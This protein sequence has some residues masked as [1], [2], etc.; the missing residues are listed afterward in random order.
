[1]ALRWVYRFTALTMSCILVACS[2]TGCDGSSGSDLRI[3][4]WSWSLPSSG[5]GTATATGTIHNHS[6]GGESGSI[7]LRLRL[8]TAPYGDGGTYYETVRADGLSQLSGGYYRDYTV[9]DP[10]SVS[11][12]PSGTYYVVLIL[13]EYTGGSGSGYTIRSGAT[14][15]TTHTISVTSSPGDGNGD[16]VETC[17][18]G[19]LSCFLNSLHIHDED[20]NDIE[21]VQ[22]Q[23]PLPDSI[24]GSGTSPEI[25]TTPT[26]V[27]VDDTDFLQS[28]NIGWTD[29]QGCQPAFCIRFCSHSVC[30]TRYGCTPSIPDGLVSGVWRTRLGYLAEPAGAVGTTEEFFFEVTPISMPNCQDPIQFFQDKQNAGEGISDLGPDQNVY[31][32]PPVTI[33]HAVI[34]ST[35]IS[36]P[37]D[38]KECDGSCIPESATCCGDG[39]FCSSISPLCVERGRCCLADLPLLC[40]NDDVCVSSLSNCPGPGTPPA[41]GQCT[42]FSGPN[43]C[44]PC[45]TDADCPG[46]GCWTG[47]PPAPFCSG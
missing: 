1:M 11:S 15:T 6:S 13:S 7:G 14:S 9:S 46:G 27:T 42:G 43:A 19:Q 37:A 47:N 40:P 3:G 4:E 24:T 8:S 45:N 2:G 31:T 44:G 41:A 16:T 25:T 32:G 35:D 18:S 33:P 10:F 38:E 17:A 20:G 23:G 39:R 30:T 34:N 28:Q 12:V 21:L 36:C 26:S 5:S 29:P 22:I